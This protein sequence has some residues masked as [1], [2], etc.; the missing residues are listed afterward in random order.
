MVAA[1][2]TLGASFGV[3]NVVASSQDA[4]G[5]LAFAAGQ[6]GSWLVTYDVP[7]FGAPFPLLVSLGRDGVVI[8]TDAPGKFPFGPGQKE[9]REL[10]NAQGPSRRARVVRGHCGSADEPLWDRTGARSGLADSRAEADGW[11]HVLI[12]M[13]ADPDYFISHVDVDGISEYPEQAAKLTAEPSIA[14][15]F[16]HL[17]AGRLDRC[18]DREA[19]ARRRS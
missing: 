19:R 18:A 9:Y 5:R 17:S 8:E 4:E 2:V 16:R 10:R 3:G 6:A 14:I 7:A 1:V 12:F 15:L 13:S 11:Y